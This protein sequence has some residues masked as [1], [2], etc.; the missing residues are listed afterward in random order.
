MRGPAALRAVTALMAPVLLLS[1]C[2]AGRG[3]EGSGAPSRP[4]PKFSSYVAL[5]D[6]YTAGPLVPTT[7]LA[8]GCLRSDH[9]Y[10]SLLAQRLQVRHFTDVSCSGATTG[11]LTHRQNTYRQAYVPAQLRAVDK[12]TDLVTVGI[13]GND[14]DMFATL[15]QTCIRLRATDP[16]GSPCTSSL[17]G[18]QSLTQT[19]RRI[20]RHV[21][22]VLRQVQRHAPQATV[23]LVGYLRVV[24][25]HGRCARL[26]LATGDYGLGRQI[27]REL[28]D[29]LA[30]AARRTHVRYLDAYAL[31]AGHDVCSDQPWVNGSRTDRQRAAAFH[32]LAAGMRAVADRL[33]TLLS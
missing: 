30:R 29:A 3:A 7:D 28:D 11:D 5:G 19:T 10:P 27:T 8:N 32:P 25:D 17:T 12:D 2:T 16:N 14:Y 21:A 4:D 15:A 23:V 20:G 22:R 18:G 13:G 1:A 31:S 24:P 33:S 9:N 26:P 6:S